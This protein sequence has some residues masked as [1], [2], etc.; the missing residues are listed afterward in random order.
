MPSV[1]LARC[2]PKDLLAVKTEQRAWM[3][4]VMA[5][6]NSSP[7]RLLHSIAPDPHVSYV[8]TGRKDKKRQHG[9]WGLLPPATRCFF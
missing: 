8:V 7:L 5:F 6:N 9:R 3:H 1:K 4:R 2:Q